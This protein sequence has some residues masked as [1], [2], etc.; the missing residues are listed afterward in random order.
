MRAYA[1][2]LSFLRS[3][4]HLTTGARFV[5]GKDVPGRRNRRGTLSAIEAVSRVDRAGERREVHRR[6]FGLR[7][8]GGGTL[9][10]T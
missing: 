1:R 9:L 8:G 3:F 5:F 10:F 4:R 7:L 6:R 2:S